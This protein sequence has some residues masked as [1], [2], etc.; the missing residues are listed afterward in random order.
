MRELAVAS[1]GGRASEGWSQSSRCTAEALRRAQASSH[2]EAPLISEDPT[3]D[4]T[5]TYAFRS[6]DKPDTVTLI[7]NV[8]SRMRILQ[9][10]RTG[11]RSRRPR[12]TTSTSTA[13]ATASRTSGG[14]FR[15]KQPASR[16][17]SSATRSR[18][19][20]SRRSST[21]S[22]TRRRQRA[23][24]AARQ[25]RAAVDA[26]LPRARAGRACRR[27][28][29]GTKVFAGQRDDRSSA[30]SARRSTSLRSATAPGRPAAARTSSP[31]T[32]CTRSRCR[33]RS[34]CSTTASPRRSA[35]WAA[36]DRPERQG[37]ARRRTGGKTTLEAG[38]AARQS[39]DQ[40]APHPDRAQ[41]QVERDDARQG[42]AVR[43]VLLEP[44]PGRAAEQALPAVRAVQGD[45]TGPTSSPC[46]LTGLKTP[47]LNFTGGTLADE[48]RLNLS[49][50]PTAPVGKGNRLGVLGGD[51][52]GWP[53][54]G[55]SRTT[56]ST[57][58]SGRSAAR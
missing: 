14:Y 20:P 48:M 50:A 10:A 13:T 23:D 19:T 36:T 37:H 28:S 53:N 32:P 22:R 54:G 1:P 55:G 27:C 15:F 3:A 26:G 5:D 18:A 33:C 8:H 21:G 44:D 31:A 16:S 39:A 46:S 7:S 49:I 34:R 42:Q 17:R 29:D 58:Q 2:R 11:T 40:R 24:D 25:H 47:N 4:N 9:R 45:R 52:A 51:L 12:G 56:S 57:S 41:G 43:A 6:P 38:L 35:C 30:T